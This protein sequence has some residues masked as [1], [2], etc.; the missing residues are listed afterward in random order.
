MKEYAAIIAAVAIG[1][2]AGLAITFDPHSKPP[3]S[4]NQVMRCGLG[5]VD[6]DTMLITC[7]WQKEP[8]IELQTP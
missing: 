4:S 5:R 1:F 2:I 7:K 3:V 8:D 6:Q